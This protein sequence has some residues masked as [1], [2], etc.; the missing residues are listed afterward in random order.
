MDVGEAKAF[1]EAWL[2][3]W[4]G[5]R[6]ADLLAFYADDAFY[7]DPG[8]PNGLRGMAQIR[9]YFERLLEANPAWEWRA[10]EVFPTPAGFTLKWRARIPVGTEV[11]EE[12]G[13]DVVE[14]D[15]GR[16]TRNEVYFDRSALLAAF[17]AKQ[18]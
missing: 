5:N 13:L 7:R 6:P 15:A 16:I 14:V 10:L 17:A 3:A 1:G 8:R 9:P 12:E 18:K 4:T 2:A 11:I